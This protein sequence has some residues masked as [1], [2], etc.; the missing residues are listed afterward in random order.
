MRDALS[1]IEAAANGERA[2]ATDKNA[3][4]EIDTVSQIARRFRRGPLTVVRGATGSDFYAAQWKFPRYNRIAMDCVRDHTLCFHLRHAAPVAK[5]VDGKLIRKHAVPGSASFVPA[6]ETARYSLGEEIVAI[7]VYMA[8]ALIRRFSEECA[9]TVRPITI[10]PFLA[11]N[12]R[13]LQGYFQMLAAEMK[14][15]EGDTAGVDSLL[16][17]QAQLLL[18]SYLVREYSDL[19]RHGRREL[20]RGAAVRRLPLPLLNRVT[21]FVAQNLSAD[22]RLADLAALAH[23]S[24]RHFIRAFRAATGIT[25]YRYLV[26]ERLRAAARLL[27]QDDARAIAD[28]ARAT[29]FKSQSHFTAEFRAR[30]RVTPTRFRRSG[31]APAWHH[32]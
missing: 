28:I 15:H 25:P 20:D 31:D 30:Y 8:P 29:G 16:L 18:L 3:T 5:L 19:G 26:D 7:E 2:V 4:R 13:W 24:Q 22:I 6:G 10:R 17:N 27:N 21:G 9:D 12:D 11:A 14:S 23:L 32:S 1:I